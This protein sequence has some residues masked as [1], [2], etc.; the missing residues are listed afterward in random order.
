MHMCI[1]DVG[2][3]DTTAVL[4]LA[5]F[6]HPI[7]LILSCKILQSEFTE[8]NAPTSIDTGSVAYYKG[9]K[10]TESETQREEWIL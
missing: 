8:L 7:A 4:Y 1:P 2:G 9:V 10:T 6:T 3:W 5:L